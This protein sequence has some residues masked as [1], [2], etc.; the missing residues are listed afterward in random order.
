MVGR[1]YARNDYGV[2]EY[3]TYPRNSVLAGQMSR[4]F[5]DSFES[6]EEARAKYPNAEERI[7]EPISEE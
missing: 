2:Y 7:L 3:G 5:L 4:T 6:L 1:T